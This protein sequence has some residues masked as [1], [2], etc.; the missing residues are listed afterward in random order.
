[1]IN[2]YA[3]LAPEQSMDVICLSCL[4]AFNRRKYLESLGIDLL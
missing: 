1:M 3:H 4:G 2:L